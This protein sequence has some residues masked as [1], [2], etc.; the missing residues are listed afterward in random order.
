MDAP[1]APARADLTQVYRAH[2]VTVVHD[3]STLAGGLCAT[4]Q[5]LISVLL[6]AEKPLEFGG[7]LV[8]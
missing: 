5:R 8:T 2:A 1:I 6:T 7:E 3:G 4:S